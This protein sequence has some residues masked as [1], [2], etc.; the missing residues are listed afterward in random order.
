M[1]VFGP[2]AS[3]NE[4]TATLDALPD[5]VCSAIVFATRESLADFQPL[6]DDDRLFYL[7]CGELPPREL[8]ALI[9]NALGERKPAATLDRYLTAASLRRIALAQSIAELT[10]ALRAAAA[11]TVGAERTR[12]VL[13]DSQRGTLWVP[14]ESDA[15][16]TAAGLVSFILRTGVAVCLPHL[17]GDARFDRD[18]DNPE[19]SSADRFLGVPILAGGKVVAVLTAMRPS[20]ALAFEPVDI[21]AMEALAAHASPYAA[22]WL[23]ESPDSGGPFRLRALRAAEQTP[24]SA[25]A[26]LQLE[27]AWMRRATWLFFASLLTLLVAFVVLRGWLGE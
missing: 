21:A 5:T 20:H 2:N 15:E 3:A 16:S 24:G 19:G 18:L 12:C 23:E 7:A 6:I 9:D 25:S 27:S 26:P 10:S 13:F 14:D 8:D 1:L 17:D 22:A 11:T 4:V